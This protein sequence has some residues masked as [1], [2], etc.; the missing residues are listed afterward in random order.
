[1]LCPWQCLSFLSAAAFWGFV[2][3]HMWQQKMKQNAKYMKHF[4][5]KS[6]LGSSLVLAVVLHFFLILGIGFVDRERPPPGPKKLDV[7]LVSE[8]NHLRPD[9]AKLV[10]QTNH[11]AKL[12]KEAM[13]PEETAVSEPLQRKMPLSQKKVENLIQLIDTQKKQPNPLKKIDISNMAL[14]DLLVEMRRKAP[15]ER[16]RTISASTYEARDALY[17]ESWQRKIER[18]GNLNYP[19]E[20]KQRGIHG[21][22]RLLVAINQDGSLRAAEILHSSGEPLLDDAALRI[23]QLAAPYSPLPPEIRKDTEVLE[24]VRTW[25]FLES[26]RFSR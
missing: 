23:V 2:L 20:A 19:S 3:E 8:A 17:L 24:I 5:Q 9:E 25:Q 6:P 14:D 4:Y 13:L 1:M 11:K 18:I 15:R 26:N 22:L 10:S 16:R 12:H 21:D 7:T